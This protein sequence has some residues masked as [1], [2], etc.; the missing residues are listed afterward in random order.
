M[1]TTQ[2]HGQHAE[3]CSAVPPGMPERGC[4]GRRT[5]ED[6]D[7]S[8]KADQRRWKT[9]LGDGFERI[10]ALQHS[11]TCAQM[12]RLSSLPG[13]QT[14]KE[15]TLKMVED[16]RAE[17]KSAVQ[18]AAQNGARFTLSTDGW[19]S[20]GKRPQH[21][22]AVI[23]SWVSE[24]RAFRSAC[25]H[26][27]VLQGKR[28]SA[29]YEAVLREAVQQAA[30]QTDDVIAVGTDHEGAVRKA[31][32]DLGVTPIGCACHAL[33]LSPQTLHTSARAHFVVVLLLKLLFKLLQFQFFFV[34][35]GGGGAQEPTAQPKGGQ[36]ARPIACAN[37][38]F[39]E[40]AF[41]AHAKDSAVLLVQ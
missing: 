14:V 7:G 24:R 40:T 4:F 25:I 19:K 31:G 6:K 11:G 34:P 32:R 2:E 21:D 27:A 20:K 26:T 13:R 33:Q 37:A 36:Q 3:S 16:M 10:A 38:R 18:H 30:L 1:C 35:G 5:S 41:E 15:H 8:P 28:D 23:L 39:A 22:A 12:R 17:L 29:A 9:L